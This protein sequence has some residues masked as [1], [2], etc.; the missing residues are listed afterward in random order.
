MQIMPAP[1]TPAQGFT[2]GYGPAPRKSGALAA[3]D[4]WNTSPGNNFLQGL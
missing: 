4:D 2:L 1:H 3:S